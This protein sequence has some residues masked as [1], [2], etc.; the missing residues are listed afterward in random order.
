MRYKDQAI[1]LIRNL[2]QRMSPSI[3]D[4][5]WLLRLK[6]ADGQ[7]YRPDYLNW[8]LER[9]FDDGSWGADIRYYHHDRIICTL[10]TAIA[11]AEQEQT[12]EILRAIQRAENYLW[13][14]THL[15]FRDPAFTELVGFELLFPALMAEARQHGMAVS[16]HNFGIGE[17]QNQKLKL[18]PPELLFSR[19]LTTIHSIEYLGRSAPLHQL[20]NA[21]FENGSLGNSPAATAFYIISS[22]RNGEAANPAAWDYLDSVSKKFT[23]TNYLYPFRNF[24]NLWVLN[25]FTINDDF[26]SSPREWLPESF[27]DQMERLVEADG[28]SLD[29]EFGIPDADCTSVAYYLLGLAGRYPDPSS[30]VKYEVP[31]ERFFR[32]YYFERNLSISTNIH[33]LEALRVMPHYPYREAVIQELEDMLLANRRF[34]LFWTDKWHA[35]PY[36]ATA[37]ALI[38]LL[39]GNPV[40]RAVC[41]ETIEWLTHAQRPNGAW[42]FF[43]KGTVEETAY[44]LLALQKAYSRGLCAADVLQRGVEYLNLHLAKMDPKSDYEEL[45]LGKCLYAPY[46]VIHSA[47]L[48]VLM[49]HEALFG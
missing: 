40:S 1:E 24:E 28:V 12:P 46:D 41:I 45:W 35:S 2:D 30:L 9:Q 42:G 3:Y 26:R 47:V 16:S 33:A 18:I 37:Y 6:S 43:N 4:T 15:L 22:Q 34:K 39:N 49:N 31:G 44:A 5:A 7:P 13:Q 20:R 11:L 48:T 25:N 8:L 32:T 27:L 36:Y 10:V 23:P 17:I 29:D 38:S 19:K 14:H 21:L